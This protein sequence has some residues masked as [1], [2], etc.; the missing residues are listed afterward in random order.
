MSLHNHAIVAS[1]MSYIIFINTENIAVDE[2]GRIIW[3]HLLA[4]DHI[5]FYIKLSCMHGA[6][7]YNI[8]II[9]STV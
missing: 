7:T 2:I 3:S 9:Y 1:S 6:V 4:R 8:V 5:Y